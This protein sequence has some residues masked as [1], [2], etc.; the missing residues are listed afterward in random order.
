MIARA[1]S[2]SS[3]FAL[4]ILLVAPVYAAPNM[5]LGSNASYNLSASFNASQSCNASHVGYNQTACGPPIPEYDM[6]IFDANNTC[7]PP[8][9]ISVSCF[10]SPGSLSVLQG[11]TVVWHNNGPVGHGVATCDS[12]NLPTTQAC[13]QLNSPGL[14]SIYTTGIF[15][16][17]SFSHTFNAL[18]TY[19][20]FD[21]LHPW[22]HGTVIVTLSAPSPRPIAVIVQ[23]GPPPI[24]VGGRIGWSVVGLDGNTAV[25][26][27][28]H[29]LGVSIGNIPIAPVSESGSFQQS[30]D[31]ATRAQALG[32]SA[33]MIDNFALPLMAL[34][35]TGS[36]T[37]TAP[38]ALSPNPF[39]S[40]DNMP[41]IYTVWWVNGPLS[42]GSPVQL[43][44][45][46][47]SVQADETVNLSGNLGSRSAWIVTSTVQESVSTI[48]PQGSSSNPGSE[49]INSNNANADLALRFDYDKSSDLLLASND[50]AIITTTSTTVYMPGQLLCGQFGTCTTVNSLTTVTHAM[51][52]NLSMSVS[53]SSTNLNL[54]RRI[55]GS[56]QSGQSLMSMLQD[57]M[58][59][60]LLYATAGV[61]AAAI[62]SA[63]VWLTKGRNK[64][65][66]PSPTPPR[67]P[68]APPQ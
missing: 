52:V 38:V 12:V 33:E 54:N 3:T 57:I 66:T 10:F 50:N 46:Y 42:K 60:P 9:N 65:A 23:S 17:G 39:S 2:L 35:L 61:A 49:P 7:G 22:M 19:Y 56:S 58:T 67:Q 25:L 20:Y 34:L 15:A 41:T 18:G 8:T 36:F 68:A 62:G 48:T 27:V 24:S 4:I 43:L 13:P 21:P 29:H 55:G 40:L 11:Y 47:S 30:I 37:S 26:N 31:L 16:G 59:Q 51:T 53:L 6:Y 32:S 28:T 5:I 45:G 64:T 44:A 14:D 1:I 63:T